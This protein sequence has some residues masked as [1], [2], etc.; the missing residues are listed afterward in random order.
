MEKVKKVE[1]IRIGTDRVTYCGTPLDV[2]YS[3]FMGV[4]NAIRAIRVDHEVAV[5]ED[6]INNVIKLIGKG[7]PLRG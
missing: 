4:D 7:L 2:Q 6:C 3:A 5:C 1:H